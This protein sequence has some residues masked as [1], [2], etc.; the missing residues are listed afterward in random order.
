[1]CSTYI[2]NAVL[3]LIKAVILVVLLITVVLAAVLAVPLTILVC[4]VILLP[5]GEPVVLAFILRVLR[6]LRL[7]GIGRRHAI[8]A[9]VALCLVTRV[10]EFGIVVC[11]AIVVARA[12]AFLHF[13]AILV[14][15]EGAAFAVRNGSLI[16]STGGPHLICTGQCR[17]GHHDRYPEDFHRC[18]IWL[19]GS[20]FL[21]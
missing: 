1:M 6:L 10:P 13:P 8:V 16:I 14:A 15:R 4:A 12:L 5:S 9:V 19:W 3:P 18:L 11:R 20:A 7:L 17:C 21:F 2:V